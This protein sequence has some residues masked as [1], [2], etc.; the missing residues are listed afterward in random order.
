M[1]RVRHRRQDEPNAVLVAVEGMARAC[2]RVAPVDR[3]VA[4]TKHLA[5]LVADEVDMA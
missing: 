1:E 3:D 5:Q 4:G 2:R